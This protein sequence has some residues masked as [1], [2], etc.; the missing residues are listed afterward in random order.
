MGQ[1]SNSKFGIPGAT[2]CAHGGVG[3]AYVH[4]HAGE[5]GRLDR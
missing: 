3:R 5:H 2:I 1:I 4:A